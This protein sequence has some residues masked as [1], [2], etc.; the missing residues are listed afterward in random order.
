MRRFAPVDNE[1][2]GKI[3]ILILG[4]ID[5]KRGARRQFGAGVRDNLAVLELD[6]AV[7]VLRYLTVVRDNDD[8]VPI[9]GQLAQKLDH[10]VAALGIERAGRLVGEQYL[11]AIHQRTRNRDALLLAAGKLIGPVIETIRKT[12]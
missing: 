9:L 1:R 10:L 8:R 12:E 2:P 5:G 4:Q 3:Q 11:A 7:G 6:Y